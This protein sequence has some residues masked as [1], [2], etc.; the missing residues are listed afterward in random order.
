MARPARNVWPARGRE[1]AAGRSVGSMARPRVR[2]GG[3]ALSARRGAHGGLGAEGLADLG[4]CL[5]V[6]T[7]DQVDAVG[8]GGEDAR[9]AL[10]AAVVLE[11]LQRLGN[12]LG[13][14]RQVDDEAL[15]ANHG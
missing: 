14:A 8:H 3:G 4:A 10:C 9:H 5:Q 13:L 2:R 1:G 6:G 15:A 7:A 11:A 12:R